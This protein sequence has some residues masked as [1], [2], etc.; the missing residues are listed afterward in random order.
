MTRPGIVHH[1][2]PRLAELLVFLAR[3]AG[4]LVTKE[5]IL[6]QVW[7]REFVA[8][9]VISR[10]IADLRRLL[11]DDARNARYIETIATRGYCLVAPVSF[12]DERPPRTE[13]S[14]AVLPFVDLA[15]DH[16]QE[17]FCD[18]LAEEL[19]NGL[20]RLPGLRVVARTSAFAFKGTSADV[21]DI[22]RQLGVGAILEGAVQRSGDRLRITVQLVDTHDSIHIWSRRFDGPAHDVFAIEDD[23][24]QAVVSALSTTLLEVGSRGL[25]SGQTADP[26][27]H[28]LYLQGRYLSARRRRDTL[29]EAVTRFERALAIDTAYAAAHA[30]IAE[31]F[32]VQAFLGFEPAADA[33][34]AAARAAERAIELSPDLGAAH[35]VLGHAR[36]MF[37]WRWDEAERH[38]RRALEL[39]Q[40][41]AVA[42]VW[43]S[44]LLTA[45]GR[46][47]EAVAETER[48]W[49]CDPLSPM[50]Q[51]ALGVALYFAGSMDRAVERFE[52]VLGVEPEFALAHFHL[53]RARAV[54]GELEAAAAEL[55]KAAPGLPLALA[56]LVAT[57]RRLG[58]SQRADEA[59]NELRRL[60]TTAYVGPL[61]WSCAYVGQRELRFGWL[62]RAFD[63]HDGPVPLA[64]VDPWMDDVRGDPEF[65]RL[66]ERLRL[67]P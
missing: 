15:S 61:A 25:I 10:S 59:L 49:A 21:R 26:E 64:Q 31:C 39:D 4:R 40:D 2:R 11:G 23:I 50:V 46:S 29:R 65:R 67:P 16:D 54:R 66:V 8:E 58:R 12:A 48:A 63:E 33:F 17:Y 57:W 42:R 56:H 45:L 41:L 13:P 30:A 6:E 55:E 7:Q 38:L 53:G 22:G 62:R 37:D 9:S 1:L 24:V 20:A 51:M 18:G 60:S 3:R 27:A 14:I 52:K 35:A 47:E 28:D 5:E 44:H 36:G 19:T 34:P 43:Y 32:A